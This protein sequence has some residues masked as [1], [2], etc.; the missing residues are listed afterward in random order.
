MNNF[1]SY[2]HVT[3]HTKTHKCFVVFKIKQSEWKKQKKKR[4]KMPKKKIF[5]RNENH[6]HNAQRQSNRI[7]SDPIRYVTRHTNT[8][9]TP[10]RSH[11]D[12]PTHSLTQPTSHCWLLVC[13]SIQIHSLFLYKTRFFS[14][15]VVVVVV[16]AGAGAVGVVIVWHV[17]KWFDSNYTQYPDYV[18]RRWSAS[19]QAKECHF[20]QT[21]T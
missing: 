7:R 6:L 12:Q 1:T 19:T 4:K 11:T 2:R 5:V 3:C 9:N 20:D 21:E 18:R 10:T 15:I 13:A 16:A 14:V 17:V 8:I